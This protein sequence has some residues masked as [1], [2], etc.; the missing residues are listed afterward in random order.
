M[1]AKPVGGFFLFQMLRRLGGIYAD[2]DIDRNRQRFQVLLH[3]R[4]D[5]I[6]RKFAVSAAELGEG[7]RSDV[8]LRISANEFLQSCFDVL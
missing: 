1:G 5:G 2:I 4:L 7:D 3:Q 6:P 8:L